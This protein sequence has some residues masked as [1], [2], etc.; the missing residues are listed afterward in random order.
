MKLVQMATMATMAAVLSV[1]TLA[2]TAGVQSLRGE[3]ALDSDANAISKYK[4][5]KAKGGFERSFEQ[6]PPMI[7]HSIEKDKITLKGNT[8][9]KCHSEKNHEKEKA[10]MVGESHF[11]DRDGN[12]LKEVSSRRWFCNQ[13]HAPQADAEPL[14]QN[15]F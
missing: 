9:M 3:S 2:A 7:P 15:K 4:Q 14:V 10:P 11:F 12:K 8:C 6:Q 13:C 5:I 1:L